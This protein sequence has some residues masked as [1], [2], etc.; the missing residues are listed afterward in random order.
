MTLFFKYINENNEQIK[1]EGIDAFFHDFKS[2][3]VSYKTAKVSYSNKTN[4]FIFTT[5]Y[6]ETTNRSDYFKLKAIG[7]NFQLIF[8]KT[9]YPDK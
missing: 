8:I 1:T 5:P 4:E 3:K 2:D 6:E 7:E 9:G